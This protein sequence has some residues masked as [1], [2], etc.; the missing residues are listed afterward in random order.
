MKVRPRS[1]CDT[2]SF[3][4]EFPRWEYE[5]KDGSGDRRRKDNNIRCGSCRLGVENYKVKCKDAWQMVQLVNGLRHKGVQI[6]KC[7]E[8]KRK[9]KRLMDELKDVQYCSD[10][11]ALV[12]KF[13]RDPTDFEHY[14]AH[15]FR[16]KGFE[17]EVT[18]RSRD[19]GYDIALTSA[20]GETAIVEC[21]C[22]QPAEKI[23]RDLVQKLVG[24]NAVYKA[25]HMIFITTS[26]FSADAISYAHQVGVKL[27]DGC[28]L[29]KLANRDSENNELPMDKWLLA[30]EDL[31]AYYPPDCPF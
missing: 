14:C 10:I 21:K 22:Y 18:S 26:G 4:L 5:N 27:I 31:M 3:Q 7:T 30:K 9:Y 2:N 25:D 16:S 11:E 17:A 13:Q 15:I 8:E 20:V 23:G 24:A 12:K 29:L 6:S 1:R 19:G 28:D